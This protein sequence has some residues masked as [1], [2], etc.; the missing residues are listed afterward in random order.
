MEAR[1]PTPVKEFPLTP[2]TA[3]KIIQDLAK[4]HSQR[5]RFGSHA[6]ERMA[7]RNVSNRQIF[8]VLRSDHSFFT[9]NPHPTAGGSWKFNLQGFAAGVTLEVV[10]DLQRHDE[11]PSAYLVTV[12]VK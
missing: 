9:E 2:Q 11:D 7:E 12:I 10:V 6:R 1:T 3:K 4:N 8:S 5:I